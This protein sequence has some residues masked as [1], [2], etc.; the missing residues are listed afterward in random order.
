MLKYN[1]EFLVDVLV[2]RYTDTL[3]EKGCESLDTYVGMANRLFDEVGQDNFRKWA[4][5]TAE[6]IRN[7][8]LATGY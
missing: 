1:K 2:W 3:L 4:S 5:L 7:F 8:K 6:E